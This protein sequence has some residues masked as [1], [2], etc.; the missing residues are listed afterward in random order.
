MYSLR[1]NR[2]QYKWLLLFALILTPFFVGF[3]YYATSPNFETQSSQNEATDAVA[4]KPVI[5]EVYPNKVKPG[6]SL[7]TTLTELGVDGV[8][9]SQLVEAA[10]PLSDLFTL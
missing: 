7:Y 4:E 5:E 3:G 8:T 2:K 6:S 10:K 1:M 9:I